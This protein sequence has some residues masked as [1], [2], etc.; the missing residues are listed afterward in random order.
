VAEAEHRRAS[1][2]AAV[3]E[4][5]RSTKNNDKKLSLRYGSSMENGVGFRTEAGPV[6]HGRRWRDGS[7]LIFNSR[8][9]KICELQHAKRRFQKVWCTYCWLEAAQAAG[10]TAAAVAQ[11]AGTAGTAA[12]DT[13]V[14]QA[15]DT[16]AAGV[17]SAERAAS[18]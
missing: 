11:V 10:N 9:Y 2:V 18:L 6:S 5:L 8:Q 15:A 16:A 12:A 1:A 4:Y 3:A 17:A 7:C 13:A 14:E